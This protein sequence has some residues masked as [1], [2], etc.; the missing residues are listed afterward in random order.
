MS[1]YVRDLVNAD[2][3]VAAKHLFCSV[4]ELRCVQRTYIHSSNSKRKTCMHPRPHAIFFSVILFFFAVIFNFEMHFSRDCIPFSYLEM[5]S[6]IEYA[7]Y[8]SNAKHL[9]AVFSS[10]ASCLLFSLLLVRNSLN[11]CGTRKIIHTKIKHTHTRR[12]YWFNA[13]HQARVFNRMAA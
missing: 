2:A 8:D 9:C 13:I 11:A 1:H 12:I 3:A 7:N 4:F 10:L 6:K 5:K